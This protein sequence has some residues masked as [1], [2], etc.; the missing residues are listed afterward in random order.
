MHEATLSLTISGSDQELI[1]AE[2]A[3]RDV[4]PGTD[5]EVVVVRRNR[6]GE[7]YFYTRAS[8]RY[9]VLVIKQSLEN[10]GLGGF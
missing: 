8:E 1:A 4:K 3:R 6:L 10:N 9:L 2:N 5:D 7:P